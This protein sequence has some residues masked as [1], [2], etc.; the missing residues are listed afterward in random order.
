MVFITLSTN[1][2]PLWKFWLWP[3]KHKVTICDDN[4]NTNTERFHSCT[5]SF[6]LHNVYHC[7]LQV[8]H[9]RSELLKHELVS[10][11]L[12]QKSKFGAAF[13]LADLFLYVLFLVFLTSFALI[14]PTPL[15]EI[16]ESNQLFILF[17]K[18]CEYDTLF[19][20]RCN[21]YFW[22][23]FEHHTVLVSRLLVFS[24]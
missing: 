22:P 8:K 11:F 3:C 20:H 13:Y 23:S 5:P 18:Y 10:T 6:N 19:T 24:S 1:S 2:T 7:L 21:K 14:V 17:H 12:R 9:R 15:D 16:C 4:L